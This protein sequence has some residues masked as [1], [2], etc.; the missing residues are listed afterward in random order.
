MLFFYW[1]SLLPV[2]R[3]GKEKKWVAPR[4]LGNRGPQ[5]PGGPFDEGEALFT[6][7][8]PH[9]ISHVMSPSP[10]WGLGSIRWV[11]TFRGENFSSKGSGV[12]KCVLGLRGG[13]TLE[14]KTDCALAS[15]CPVP[16]GQLVVSRR[17]D[18]CSRFRCFYLGWGVPIFCSAS[19]EGPKLASQETCATVCSQFT[20]TQ[21]CSSQGESD[22]Q[23][24]CSAWSF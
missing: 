22:W 5:D 9:E 3:P 16:L 12:V 2:Q 6:R 10:G 20:Q 17:M 7:K 21:R 1:V 8:H 23:A 15:P 19:W 14:C 13:L 18:S 11:C 24:S 4:A